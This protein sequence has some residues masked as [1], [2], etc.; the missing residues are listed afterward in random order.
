MTVVKL[1]I[2]GDGFGAL[3]TFRRGPIPTYG[4]EITVD[5]VRYSVLDVKRFTTPK[6]G[7]AVRVNLERAERPEMDENDAIIVD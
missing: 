7:D 2:V 3:E 6:R 1:S 4:D 5:G